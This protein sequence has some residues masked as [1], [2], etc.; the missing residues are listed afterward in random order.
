MHTP[1]TIIRNEPPWSLYFPEAHLM[2][3]G[4]GWFLNDYKGRLA[5]HHGGNI[6]GMSSLVAMLP[7]EKMGAVILTN[8]NGSLLPTVMAHRIFDDQ[9]KL[10][11]TDYSGEMRVKA[12]AL[13]KQAKEALAK[14]EA[15]RVPNTRPTLALDKYAG[16]YTDSMYGD[17]TV[18]AENGK[19]AISYG[20][21]SDGELVHWH[22]DSFRAVWGNRLLGKMMVTFV[23]DGTVK[24][25]EMKVE[26]LADFRRVPAK[27][28]T[29]A[30][31]RVVLAELQKFVGKFGAKDVPFTVDV[32]VVGSVLKM[33]VPGQPSYTL[34]PVSPTRF[35]LSGDGMPDGFFVDYTLDGGRVKSVKLEQP[36]PQP[37]L[38][39]TPVS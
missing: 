18:R 1:H 9:L 8:M 39:L 7:E 30:G 27:A 24:V 14:L 12:N 28:D 21:E 2:A 23:I 34:V 36:A 6:D 11:P 19:L 3:Y 29:T 17:M 20:G 5:V 13:E 37:T 4:M 38:V 31:V 32:Q 16:I 35:R 26:N 33:S 22:Y 15:S 25:A 10:P